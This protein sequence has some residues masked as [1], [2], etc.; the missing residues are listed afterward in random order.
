MQDAENLRSARASV[1][2][3]ALEG[4]NHVL[5]VAPAERSANLATYAD[6]KLP[7]AVSVVDAIAQFLDLAR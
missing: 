1:A 2:L 7:I 5:K 3:V 6:P 4:V